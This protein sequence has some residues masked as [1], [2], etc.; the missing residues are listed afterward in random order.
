MPVPGRSV[1]W[2]AAT[3]P[4]AEP[5]AEQVEEVYAVLD[6]QPAALAAVPEPVF[7]G[8]A[9]VGGVVLKIAV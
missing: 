9:F 5:A 6:E 8:Q 3:I 1:R 4:G 7:R 2:A